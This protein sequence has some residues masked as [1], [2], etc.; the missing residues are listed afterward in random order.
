MHSSPRWLSLIVL[1]LLGLSF[2]V[3]GQQVSHVPADSGSSVVLQPILKV[4]FS[5]LE[6]PAGQLKAL[7]D[8]LAVDC[9]V[10][11]LAGGPS[12]RWPIFYKGDGVRNEDW[13]GW[14]AMVLAPFDGTVDSVYV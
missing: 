13:Y 5:C 6:H 3:P 11:A 4:H 9:L 14:R 12:A 10:L 1:L 2:T 7:G 8:A